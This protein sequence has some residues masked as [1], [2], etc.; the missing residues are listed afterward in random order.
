M[1]DGRL[2]MVSQKYHF[3][4]L[5]THYSWTNTSCIHVAQDNQD[6]CDES[7]YSGT[8]R[9]IPKDK[10]RKSSGHSFHT[11]WITFFFIHRWLILF[12]VFHDENSRSIHKR[13]HKAKRHNR[14]SRTNTTSNLCRNTTQMKL[15]E[16]YRR[17]IQL[18]C[19]KPCNALQG[20]VNMCILDL[21]SDC[22]ILDSVHFIDVLLLLK[23]TYC[24]VDFDHLKSNLFFFQ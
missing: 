20:V 22:F 6:K 12:F 19:L 23:E 17:S 3:D 16:K 11:R 14:K 13:T 15:L 9:G 4:S 7:K 10:R 1:C 24:I 2:C 18:N 21:W 5:L 8:L